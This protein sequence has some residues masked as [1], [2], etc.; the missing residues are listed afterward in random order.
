MSLYFNK[1]VKSLKNTKLKVTNLKS[2]FNTY[3]NH[4]KQM[5]NDPKKIR[6]HPSFIKSNPYYWTFKMKTTMQESF[7]KFVSAIAPGKFRQIEN[8][9]TGSSLEQKKDTAKNTLDVIKNTSLFIIEKINL[10][11]KKITFNKVDIFKISK[12]LMKSETYGIILNRTL[13]GAIQLSAA[14]NKNMIIISRKVYNYMERYKDKNKNSEFMKYN[15][16]L[17][18]KIEKY[19]KKKNGFLSRL[20]PNLITSVKFMMQSHQINKVNRFLKLPRTVQKVYYVRNYFDEF[21]SKFKRI[22]KG[23]AVKAFSFEEFKSRSKKLYE[24]RNLFRPSTVVKIMRTSTKK[25][26]LKIFLYFCLAMFLLNAIKYL[27]NS[28]FNRN[29]DKQLKEALALVKDLKK[30]NDELMKYNLQFME[31]FGKKD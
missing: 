8:N 17:S 27:M 12:A 25:L 11:V 30:Q 24:K 15:K 2:D 4:E 18:T 26:F 16:D 1:F 5:G 21:V 28:L 29:K 10:V 23:T 14:I 19:Y 22:E 9:Q 7:E 6:S 13:N 20:I 3:L 31:R